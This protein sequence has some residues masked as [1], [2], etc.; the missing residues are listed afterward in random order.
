M[1]EPLP[2][3]NSQKGK[4]YAAPSWSEVETDRPAPEATDRALEILARWL[5]R[6]ALGPGTAANRVPGPQ[7]A[8]TAPFVAYSPKERP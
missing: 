8:P 7:S 3:T 1:R 5:V 2:K 4:R 6:D